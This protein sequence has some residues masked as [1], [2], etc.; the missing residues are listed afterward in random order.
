MRFLPALALAALTSAAALASGPASALEACPMER[1][2]YTAKEAPEYRMEF[3]ADPSIH[4]M[5]GLMAQISHDEGPVEIEMTFAA[6]NRSPWTATPGGTV[7]ALNSDFSAAR[8][9]RTGGDAPYA[10]L[11]GDLWGEGAPHSSWILTECR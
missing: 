6:G 10:I 5:L 3:K 11:I 8:L 7:F 9:P 4:N 1:A 2:V